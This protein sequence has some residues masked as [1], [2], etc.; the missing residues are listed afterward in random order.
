MNRQ[1]E[2]HI[3]TDKTVV[4]AGMSD[5]IPGKDM[6]VKDVFERADAQMYRRKTE[7]KSMGARTR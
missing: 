1:M 4:S 6:R 2:D 5:Y 3:G 7:L